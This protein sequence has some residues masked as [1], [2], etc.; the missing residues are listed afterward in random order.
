M[1]DDEELHPLAR[2]LRDDPRY[3]LEAYQFVREGLDY[4]QD[5]LGFGSDEKTEPGPAG[6]E[7]EEEIVERAGKGEKRPPKPSRHVTGQQLSHALRQFASDQFGLMAKLVLNSWGINST[8]DFG[9]IVYNLIEI[10]AM[11]KS[12]GDRREDFDD[13]FDF[14]DAFV[15]EFAITK[16]KE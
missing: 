9:S 13:V 4:A 16:A 2:M 6:E 12:K 1:S 15:K 3:K 8:S 14:E 5:V 10:G 7:P 11:S